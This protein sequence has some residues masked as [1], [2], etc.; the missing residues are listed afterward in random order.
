MQVKYLKSLNKAVDGMKKISS[1][2]WSPNNRR[3][4]VAT[5]DRYIHL[6]DE[7]GNPMERF[8]TK[9]N[10]K[11]QNSYVVRSLQFS[12]D[13]QKLAV[14]Q[15]DNIIFIYKLGLEWNEKKSI[16]NKYEQSS[17]VTCMCWPSTRQNEVIFGL[18]EGKVRIGYIKK[19]YKSESLYETSSYVVSIAESPN[20]Q[21][22]I[23]G[24]LDY[25]IIR[26]DIEKKEKIQIIQHTS[27][28]Y[29]LDWGHHIVAAVIIN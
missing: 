25:S 28:P 26:M 24:H 17:S 3:L 8:L 10:I 12:S 22:I 11:G 2:C 5:A 21:Y 1:I 16:I 20:S 18:A 7:N 19:Q 14:A 23:S 15:S 13:N 29:A 27:I 4:A 6:F 9:P